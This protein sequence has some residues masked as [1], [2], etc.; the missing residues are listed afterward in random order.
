MDKL[1][2]IKILST[3]SKD[4][5]LEFEKFTASPYFNKGRNYIPLLKELYKFY[6]SFD[7]ERLTSEYIYSKLFTDKEHNRSVIKTMFTGLYHLAEKFLI[8]KDLEAYPFNREMNLLRQLSIRN[9]DSIHDRLFSNLISRFQKQKVKKETFESFAKIQSHKVD[10]S[11]KGNFENSIM[12][13]IPTRADFYIFSFIFNL[14]N[15]VRDLV[16]MRDN[17]NITVQKDLSNQIHNKLDLRKLIEYTDNYYPDLSPVIKTLV[18]CY[19]ASVTTDN[20]YFEAKKLMLENYFLF[21]KNLLQEILVIMEG[22]VSIRLR[23]GDRRF[24]REWHEIHRFWVDNRRHIYQVLHPLTADNM[25]G[26]AFW[27]KEYAWIES[28][29]SDHQNNFQDDFKNYLN[30]M[31]KFYIHCSKKEFREALTKLSSID[32]KLFSFKQKVRGLQLHIYYELNEY[33]LAFNGIDSYRHFITDNKKYN[34]RS[35]DKS[36]VFISI[37]K[38]LLQNKLGQTKN[39]KQLRA[40]ISKEVPAQGLDWIIEKINELERVMH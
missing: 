18:V 23:A 13:N 19:T 3:F 25:M 21:D 1:K 30:V 20:I 24:I 15:E 7:S 8:Q 28:F 5:W 16:V 9:I 32:D 26:I 2:L 10:H 27:N 40:R 35:R 29:I 22:A 11:M 17:Y 14:L 12:E 34:E 33:E 38:Q 6:P 39:L 37:Y 36:L 4:E 31:G